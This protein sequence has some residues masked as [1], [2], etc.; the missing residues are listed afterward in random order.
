MKKL[1]NT[2][3]SFHIYKLSVGNAKYFFTFFDFCH[4]AEFGFG[5]LKSLILSNTDRILSDT[6][7][8]RHYAA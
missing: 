6:D 4:C 1:N 5:F 3:H 2:V 8:I 7:Q